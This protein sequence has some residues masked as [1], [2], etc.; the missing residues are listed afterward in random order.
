[1]GEYCPLPKT[2]TSPSHSIPTS[3]STT[4]TDTSTDTNPSFTMTITHI[5][6]FKYR[7][8]IPWTDLQTHFAEFALLKTQCLKDSKP[9]MLSL[10][11]GINTS[12]ET[13]NKGM[14]HGFVLEF[15][16]QADLDYYLTEDKVHAD[17]SA[18]ALPLIEDSVVVGKWCFIILHKFWL[19]DE[20]LMRRG[21]YNGSSPVRAKSY[22]ALEENI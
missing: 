11:A 8:S 2:P 19:W 16:S 3:N 15:A 14:T 13:H 6:L 1:M 22:Y 17:F 7:P 12:W 10:K 21:R 5:V 4:T 18:K 9:Y 20:M